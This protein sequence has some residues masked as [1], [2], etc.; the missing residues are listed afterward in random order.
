[1]LD[2]L[3]IGAG[4]AGLAVANTLK[5]EGLSV[6]VADKGA[7]A[8]HISEY[9]TFMQFFSTRELLEIDGFPLTITEEKPSRRQYLN[10]LTRFAQDRDI[11]LQTF[12]TVE[13]VSKTQGGSFEVQIRQRGLEPETVEARSVVVA[14]G[15]FD[16][17]RQLNVPGEDLPKVTHH[18][19]EAHPYAGTEVLIVGGRNSAIETALELYRSGANVSLSYRRPELRGYG[20]K[21]WIRPDIENRIKND[22]IKGYM[23]TE[24][25]RIDWGT[26]TLRD[27]ST[28]KDFDIANDFVICQTGYDPPAGFLRNMGIEIEEGTN[29]PKHDPETLETNVPG[30]FIAGT[31]IAG[32]VSGHVFIENSRHHGDMILKGLQ[33]GELA[34]R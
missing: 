30:L 12:T 21:Y 32:N 4:P 6:L 15:A 26:V 10:Y 25:A 18:F 14:C 23:G 2:T 31:I 1:M 19:K 13:K 22:E 24:I 20:I 8:Q 3:I 33:Q 11:P 27:T 34:A 7:I 28:G 17:P 5:K 9:P 16:N 29:I